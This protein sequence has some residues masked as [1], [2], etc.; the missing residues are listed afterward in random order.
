MERKQK[1]E[2]IVL[3]REEKKL[4]AEIKRHPHTKCEYSEVKALLSMGLIR[5]DTN[6]FDSLHQ[7]ILLDT[8]CVSDFYKV[9][10]EYRREKMFWVL[11]QSF[12][13]PLAVSFVTS[14]VMNV[15]IPMLRGA[16]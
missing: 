7:A 3:S 16:F 10:L 14:L 8:Y 15:V 13:M 12:W 9:Y 1:C 4:L 5:Q 2:S 6:G 11:T